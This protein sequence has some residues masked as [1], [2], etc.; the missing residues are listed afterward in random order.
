MYQKTAIL[1]LEVAI[2]FGS[3]LASV[4]GRDWDVDVEIAEIGVVDGQAV[5][6]FLIVWDF[7]LP[8]HSDRM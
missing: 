8:K 3:V 5:R 7:V 6:Q 2:Q 4:P 1:K